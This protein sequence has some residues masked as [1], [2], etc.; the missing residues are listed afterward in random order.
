MTLHDETTLTRNLRPLISAGWV[1]VRAREDRREKWLKITSEGVAKL[2]V[3]QLAWKR[4]QGKMQSRLSGEVW[5]NLLA[6][7]PEVARQ[8]AER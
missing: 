4:A 1:E 8:A 3:A 6:L 7:L 5:E 2:K